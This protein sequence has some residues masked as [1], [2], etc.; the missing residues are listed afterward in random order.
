MRGGLD[1][2]LGAAFANVAGPAVLVGMDTPQLDP[3]IVEAAAGRSPPITG[4]QCSAW[5]TTADSGSLRSHGAD[6][7]ISRGYR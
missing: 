5:P 6:R 7:R 2:R 3:A 4:E 1:R